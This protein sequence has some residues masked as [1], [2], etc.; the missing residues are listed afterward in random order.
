MQS[1]LAMVYKRAPLSIPAKECPEGVLPVLA[2]NCQ[3]PLVSHQMLAVSVGD[4]DFVLWLGCAQD[5][6]P[7][8]RSIPFHFISF[9]F[10]S[11]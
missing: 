11:I 5:F 7:V 3:V 1:N 6:H 10:I 8:P 4:P 2:A 9:H